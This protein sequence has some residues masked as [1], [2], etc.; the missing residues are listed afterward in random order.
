MS[1]PLLL[2]LASCREKDLAGGKAINLGELLRAGLPVPDGFVV[3]TEASRRLHAHDLRQD[4]SGL[5]EAIVAQWRAMGSPTVAVRSS[6]TAEDLADASMAGQYETFLNIAQGDALLNAVQCCWASLD[7]PRT[8]AYLTEHGIDLWQVSMAVVVQ[9]Q[10]PADVAGVLFT[11]NPHTGSRAEMLIEASWGLGEA[12]VSGRVQPDVLR[13]DRETGRIIEAKIA[14]KQVWIAPGEH[15]ESPVPEDRRNAPCLND[16][17]IA[18]IVAIARQAEAHFSRPQDI[19]WAL[20]EGRVFLLQSRPI[21]TIEQAQMREL[22]MQSIRL[23]VAELI[24]GGRGPFVLH[25]LAETLKHP[26]TLSWS[27]VQRFMSP[28]G[29]YGRMYRMAGF[30]PS[31]RLG[32]E[33]FLR[34][35]GGRI[36]MDASA[37]PQMF[38][39]GYP[40]RYELERLRDNPDA[41]QSPP[42]LAAGPLSARVRAM[43][44][45]KRADRTLRRLA[46]DLDAR[47]ERE[48]IP[49]F[50]A[51]V[52][53]QKRVDLAGLSGEQWIALWQERR[54][55]VLDEFAPLALL[56]S[57]VAAMAIGDLKSLLAELF[58]DDDPEELTR[59]LSVSPTPDQTLLSSI[60]LYQ[61]AQG[62][63]G[64]PHWLDMY[65]HRAG[66]EFDLAAP[67]WRERRDELARAVERLRTGADPSA[68][69][70]RR[71]EQV[72]S[73]LIE[74]E[75]RLSLSECDE[76]HRRL[77]LVQ[78]YLPYRENGKHHL[79]LGYDLLR[80]MALDAGRRLEIGEG[81][82][83]L[84]EDELLGAM[85]VGTASH[86]LI[87]HRTLVHSAEAALAMPM[88]IESPA[89]L[90][91][92]AVVDL[93]SVYSAFAVSPGVA[94]GPAR[95][96]RSVDEAGELGGGYILVCPSTDPG[97]MPL[98][99]N[100]AGVVLE[101]GGTLSHGA[102][103]AR[104][105]NL[106]AVVLPN[107]TRL[108]TDG[109]L[110][111]VD[112]RNGSVACGEAKR[113]GD[114]QSDPKPTP[115]P[116]PPGR[117]ERFSWRL[118]NFAAVCWGVFL[119]A[120]VALP[121]RWLYQPAMQVLD[122][123]L[124]P[125][126]QAL[127]KALAVAAIAAG[128]AL[129][130]LLI[131][132]FAT[133]NRRLLEAK[134]RVRAMRAWGLDGGAGRVVQARTFAAS[135]VP[136][137]LL[138]GPMVLMFL[139]LGDRMDPAGWSAQPG[140][141]VTIIASV[142]GDF[143]DGITIDP[144]ELTLDERLP[145]EQ[146]ALPVRAKLQQ[147]HDELAGR[148]AGEDALGELNHTL[149]ARAVQDLREYLAGPLPPQ[150]ISWQL[151]G[152][153]GR[154]GAFPV[155]VSAGEQTLAV[156]VALG[157]VPPQPVEI[158][159]ASSPIRA[160]KVVYP[161]PGR[162]PVFSTPLAWAGLPHWE[163]GW[164][165]IYLA[166]YL[167]VMFLARWALRLA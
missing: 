61:V 91:A 33:G 108:F 77:E 67:R 125:V 46:G 27:V 15:E 114:S 129:L 132:K 164:L 118:R 35:I 141:A 12:V 2:D 96:L 154:S 75:A 86:H 60:Q 23:Q 149:R 126:V 48:V 69:H 89:D 98:F 73:R 29:G 112:G 53:E 81:V 14:D 152:E 131:Q 39:E 79:M 156:R 70:T 13:V 101:C 1:Q 83:H 24:A 135:L 153:A 56:P 47:L 148:Q 34:R 36:Y 133:D 57:L 6:A 16:S 146:R 99:V 9:R 5:A 20:H 55:K 127:G 38:C 165:M 72:R 40:F 155:R 117:F 88:M 21:T 111:T 49:Q 71:I 107:A 85:R 121:E 90:D 68:A 137:A 19:E 115:L 151:R 42:T 144:G 159:S 37:A 3:T 41:S 8:R 31:L 162:R 128:M 7:S 161:S 105:M 167:P 119:L 65:G 28:E 22:T 59:L 17:A 145:A 76:L 163:A 82:F 80:D 157:D 78:R 120:V 143:A 52:G 110:I 97:W 166:A 150:P 103:V 124:W 94:S 134:R 64:L 32:R 26:T 140:S 160:L 25:N 92:P 102:V 74:L 106:P 4:T 62:E 136:L 123:G 113:A 50:L 18:Q 58:W 11:A 147:W 122:A 104:E 139:W 84:S 10:I 158:T 66:D 130:I 44:L 142:D 63:R 109:Q 100:A 116:P 93:Q 87:A 95:I 30:A 54:R 43:R 138:L 51:W 45:V